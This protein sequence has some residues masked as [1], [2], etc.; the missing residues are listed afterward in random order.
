[1][2]DAVVDP[3]DRYAILLLVIKNRLER[4]DNLNA[5]RHVSSHIQSH[6]T[7]GVSYSRK[8]HQCQT[9]GLWGRRLRPFCFGEVRY[10]SWLLTI[11]YIERYSNLLC[12]CG[13][14][15]AVNRRVS[16]LTSVR[17][18]S[19]VQQGW[20]LVGSK[21]VRRTV[22]FSNKMETHCIALEPHT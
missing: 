12:P 7:T 19:H 21:S 20:R 11:L 14:Q 5:Y 17:R 15:Y 8:H 18:E 9:E 3:S 13:I 22:T 2:C 1:M 6:S 16:S 10:P 4:R